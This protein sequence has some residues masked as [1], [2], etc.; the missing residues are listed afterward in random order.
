LLGRVLY[1]VTKAARANGSKIKLCTPFGIV[2]GKIADPAT[3]D[4]P[5]IKTFEAAKGS[6]QTGEV[7]SILVLEGVHVK[8]PGGGFFNATNLV[9]CM[10]IIEAVSID[11]PPDS[12]PVICV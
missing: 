8:V 7:G 5:A 9:V 4:S 6:L 3:T 12:T 11:E 10:D 1:E 2:E